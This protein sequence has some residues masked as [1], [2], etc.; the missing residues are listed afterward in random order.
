MDNIK[1]IEGVLNGLKDYI[2]EKSI[3]TEKKWNK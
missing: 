1:K 2:D 3:G